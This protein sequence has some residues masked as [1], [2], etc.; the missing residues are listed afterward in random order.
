MRDSSR[1]DEILSLIER[2]WKANPDFRFHQ[3]MYL[4]QHEYSESHNQ[5]GKVESKDVDGFKQIGYDLF[6]LEDDQFQKYLQKSLDNGN[7][8][9]K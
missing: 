8:Y 7:W 9:R 3:L 5:L 2:I 4:L 1:I 6:N